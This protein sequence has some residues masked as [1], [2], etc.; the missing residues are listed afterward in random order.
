[1]ER[2]EKPAAECVRLIDELNRAWDPEVWE[3]P[4]VWEP[5]VEKTPFSEGVRILDRVGGIRVEL[6]KK[7]KEREDLDF[8]QFYLRDDSSLWTYV[9]NLIYSPYPVPLT[10][11][12]PVK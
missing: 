2:L 6:S 12:F 11:M 10:E 1:M 4:L 3:S 8:F 7:V 9:R 5:L